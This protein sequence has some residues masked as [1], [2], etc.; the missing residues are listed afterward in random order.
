MAKP[1]QFG[2]AKLEGPNGIASCALFL[3]PQYCFV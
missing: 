1:K 2:D 3:G